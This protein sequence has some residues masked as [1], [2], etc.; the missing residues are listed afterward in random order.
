MESFVHK[1]MA[2]DI[3]LSAEGGYIVKC[4]WIDSPVATESSD[5]CGDKADLSLLREA[6]RQIDAYLNRKLTCFDL[7]LQL[8][9]TPFQKD[10]W[11]C[12]KTIPYG[13]TISYK[14]LAIRVGNPK[15]TRAVAGACGRNPVPIIVPCHR[16]VAANA[17]IGGYTGG[18]DKKRF[19]LNLEIEEAF[20]CLKG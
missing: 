9:G 8:N 15:A 19:L 18:L 20:V 13:S 1:T 4:K 10:V 11:E 17:T 5:E 7:P 2:G 14:D 12:L 6:T 16:V 3:C